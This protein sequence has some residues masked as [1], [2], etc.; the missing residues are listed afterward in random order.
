MNNEIMNI[1]NSYFY[2][3]TI[4]Y[5]YIFSDKFNKCYSLLLY[6][7]RYVPITGLSCLKI[8]SIILSSH[9]A[10]SSVYNIHPTL[11]SVH[12]TMYTIQCTGYGVQPTLY[13]IRISIAQLT[14]NHII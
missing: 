11:Y 6:S 12:C 5:E 3:Y 9:V 14:M 13:D 10:T 7:V 2:S 1:I 4:V 8:T